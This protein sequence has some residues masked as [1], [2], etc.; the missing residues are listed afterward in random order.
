MTS[1]NEPPPYHHVPQ[2]RVEVRAAEAGGSSRVSRD[3]IVPG[4]KACYRLDS[5]KSGKH[6]IENEGSI[7]S[8]ELK[9]NW[10][11][12]TPQNEWRES[13]RHERIF[14]PTD[15]IDADFVF[16]YRG[17]PTSKEE[18]QAFQDI[19]RNQ[20]YQLQSQDIE[21]LEKTLGDFADRESSTMSRIETREINGKQVVEVDGHWK[22]NG[23]R[24]RAIIMNGDGTGCQPH[25]LYLMAPE[26]VFDKYLIMFED[27]LKTIKWR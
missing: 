19:L 12:A 1:G 21:H 26:A 22:S 3:L 5:K 4:V 13:L 23:Q 18:G 2:P 9:G 7:K 24:F 25:H 14:H 15:T 20:N 10:R 27:S 11:D 8:M 16:Y 17:R 6:M